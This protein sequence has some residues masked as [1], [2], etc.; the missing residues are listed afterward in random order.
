MEKLSLRK[1]LTVIR[2]YFSGLPYKE[3][4]GKA[5]I[6]TGAVANVISDLKAGNYPEVGD[7]SEQVEMLKELAAE[8]RKSR[9]TV[10]EAVTGIAIVNCLKELGLEPGDMQQCLSLCQA[11]TPGDA[12]TQAFVRAAMEYKEALQRTGL[13]VEELAEKVSSLEEASHQLEPLAAKALDLQKELEDLERKKGRLTNEVAALEKHQHTLAEMVKRREQ[14]ESDLSARIT[15]LEERLQSDEEQLAVARKDLKSLSAIG[16]SLDELSGFAERLKGVAQRQGID[17]KALYSR[18]LT[19]L[20]HLDKGLTLETLIQARQREI[21]KLEQAIAKAQEKSATLDNQNQQLHK[22]LSS[23]KAQIADERETVSRELKDIIAVAQ[24]TVVEL[25]QDL[26]KGI[27]EGINETARLR[28]EALE[29]GK[30]LG[31][32]EAT[33][34]NN[35]W[36][37]NTLSLLKGEDK[38][39]AGEVRVIGLVVLKSL[40]VWLE[41][42]LGYD[43]TYYTLKRITANLV[44]ELEKWK[45]KENSTEGSKSFSAN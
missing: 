29:T 22:E 28:K 45:P 15:H 44:G 32:L 39:T 11:L 16:M 26:S 35:A 33:I 42:N 8:V 36:L 7:I 14:R 25:K 24:K 12:E 19:E 38:V 21:N 10:G 13:G 2:L 4:A 34:K 41:R 43:L 40:A 17:P 3:I 23:L 30:E 18:L 9:L 6:S 27:Q 31:E 20:E 5:G 1:Q 37:A